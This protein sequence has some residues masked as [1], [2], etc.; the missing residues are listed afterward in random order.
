MPRLVLFPHREQVQQVFVG[1]KWWL[2][3]VDG[4]Q[5]ADVAV[6][7][8]QLSQ[9]D[10]VN[11]QVVRQSFVQRNQIFKVHTQDG[12]FK[13]TGFTVYSSVV[14]VVTVGGEQLCELAQGLQTENEIFLG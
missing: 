12:N 7:V 9:V 10:L 6:Q 2:A 4:Q 11:L 5:I 14:S 8:L 3:L 1:L 13:A